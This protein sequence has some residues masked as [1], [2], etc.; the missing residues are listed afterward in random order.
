MG[1]LSGGGFQY[2]A[3]PDGL[4]GGVNSFADNFMKQFNTGREMKMKQ[5][6]LDIMNQMREAQ[7]RE[8]QALKSSIPLS[9]SI[10]TRKK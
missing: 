7:M 3:G 9:S 5:A 4:S 6:E 8:I 10:S 1:L 2:Y